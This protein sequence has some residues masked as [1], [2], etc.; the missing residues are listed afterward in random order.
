MSEERGQLDGKGRSLWRAVVA[1][2]PV[3]AP[4]RGE[5][6]VLLYRMNE[7]T[8]RLLTWQGSDGEVA[9]PALEEVYELA[10][11]IAR[12]NCRA[13]LADLDGGEIPEIVLLDMS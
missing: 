12:F 11:D 10:A 1:I 6:A 2:D 8:T 7:L 13:V 4:T 5:R 3:D 9:M